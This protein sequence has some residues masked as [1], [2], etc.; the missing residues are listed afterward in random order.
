MCGKF[1][2]ADGSSEASAARKRRST[3]RA[4]R[5]PRKRTRP[6]SPSSPT[7]RSSAPRSGPSPATTSVTSG[8]AASASS[9]TPS[10][11]CGPSRPAKTSTCPVELELLAQ[12]L[13]RAA[14]AGSR[15]RGSGAP[16]PAPGSSPQR[17]R[18]VTQV[19][20]RAEDVSS[21]LAAP[22]SRDI[23]RNARARSAALSLELVQRAG[24]ARRSASRA[25]TPRRRRASRRAGGAPAASRSRRA[26]SCSS[27][28]RRR[29][30]VRP[31]ARAARPAR[32]AAAS[33]A[34]PSARGTADAPGSAA[35]VVTTSTSC[36]R[37]ARK[38][39]SAGAWLAGP[40]GS[41]GQIPET[42]TTLTA[43]TRP[44]PRRSEASHLVPQAHDHD[45]PGERRTRP[46]RRGRRPPLP[47][48]PIRRRAR[49][50]SGIATI[51]S[52]PCVTIRSRGRPMVTGSDF[53]QP[54][55]KWIAAAIRIDPR[56][57]DGAVVLRAEDD[58]DEPRH[59][60]EEHRYGHDHDRSRPLR[61]AA[62]P[63]Q[64]ARAR[65]LLPVAG[66]LREQDETRGRARRRESGLRGR[67]RCGRDRP[68]SCPRR[69][70]GSAGSTSCAA[71]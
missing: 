68:A 36:P 33:A 52:S 70:R 69:R 8:R 62:H 38:S 9:A 5:C 56:R 25:R 14:W 59:G 50:T 43:G 16:R 23:R 58:P 66:L 40:P 48:R 12:L 34:A 54:S 2:Q 32:A 67:A 63:G 26:G 31:R 28:R 15:A 22:C 6:S 64:H 24:V 17:E 55:A 53:V 57:V 49:A 37:S 65:P 61:V 42:T 29:R 44:R 27:R 13:A 4:G 11:F 47:S 35:A 3:A 19:R 10:A 20:A 41:G 7:R 18:D 30:G 46:S 71:R 60:H 21:A 39:A 45:E 1:S 51:V